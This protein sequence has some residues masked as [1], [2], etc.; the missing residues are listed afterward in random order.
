MIAWGRSR[1]ASADGIIWG[2]AG[3]SK[4]EVIVFDD[5]KVKRIEQNI[6]TTRS[7]FY[8]YDFVNKYT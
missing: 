5:Q 1:A 4:I 3:Q 2:D 7:A 6:R 8:S